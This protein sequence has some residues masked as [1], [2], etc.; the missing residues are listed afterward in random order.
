MQGVMVQGAAVRR[1]FAFHEAYYRY[2][3]TFAERLACLFLS[4]FESR[5]WS[6]SESGVTNHD[7]A[8]IPHPLGVGALLPNAYITNA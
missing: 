2:M 1:S 5:A 7:R 4:F 3:T 8:K 6:I